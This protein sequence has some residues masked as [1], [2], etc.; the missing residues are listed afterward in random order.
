M[1]RPNTPGCE[2][3]QSAQVKAAQALR[4]VN[5]KL[6]ESIGRYVCM[7]PQEK[8]V[9]NDFPEDLTEVH[10]YLLSLLQEKV[11][12]VVA[13]DMISSLTKIAKRV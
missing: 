1:A 7:K 8:A 5:N 3:L 12:D 4:F 13:A 9:G 6:I 2:T 10:A 11:A